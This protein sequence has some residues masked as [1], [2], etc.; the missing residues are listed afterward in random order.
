[1]LQAPRLPEQGQILLHATA[2]PFSEVSL[3]SLQSMCSNNNEAVS[4]LYTFSFSL[5][6]TCIS[7][8]V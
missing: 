5:F 4:H 2:S 1:M 3:E 6:Y 7:L 8:M